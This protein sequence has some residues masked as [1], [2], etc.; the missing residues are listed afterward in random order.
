MIRGFDNQDNF[1]VYIRMIILLLVVI[2][3]GLFIVNQFLSF[4]Y[5]A[6]LINDPCELCS[7][8]KD[9]SY[10]PTRDGFIS[11]EI[12]WSKVNLSS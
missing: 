1:K 8:Y 9:I 5:K 7:E 12:N 6:R 11:L 2:A 4:Q 3:I 10:L